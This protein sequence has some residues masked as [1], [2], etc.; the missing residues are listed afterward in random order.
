MI[1]EN[2]ERSKA[3]EKERERER[4]GQRKTISDF[5]H[6]PMINVTSSN[7]SNNQQFFPL[8]VRTFLFPEI[9]WRLNSKQLEKRCL[10][11][12]FNELI[13][14]NNK[15]EK[16]R[17]GRKRRNLANEYTNTHTSTKRI[18]SSTTH[19]LLRDQLF[20]PSNGMHDVR[21]RINTELNSIVN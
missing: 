18:C 10:L 6:N 3:T 15:Y 17:H 11:I 7:V 19:R 5:W 13:S 20:T 14:I 9:S 8:F 2:T 21:F 4:Q 1:D 12:S 16:K